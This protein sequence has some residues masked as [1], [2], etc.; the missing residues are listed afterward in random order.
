MVPCE[1]VPVAEL[2]ANRTILK[3]DGHKLKKQDGVMVKGKSGTWQR[4]VVLKTHGNHWFSGSHSGQVKVHY[5]GVSD[6]FDSWIPRDSP[7]IGWRIHLT[8]FDEQKDR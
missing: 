3:A 8:A 6:T 7:R 5:I 1:Q 2:G 4:A